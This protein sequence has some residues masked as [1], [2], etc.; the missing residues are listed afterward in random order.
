MEFGSPSLRTGRADLPHPALRSVVLPPRGVMNDPPIAAETTTGDRRRIRLGPR[1]ITMNTCP[2]QRARF[3]RRRTESPAGSARRHWAEVIGA[4]VH[5]RSSTFLRPL[6]PGPLQALRRF[7]GR[8]DSCSPSSSAFLR[9]ERRLYGEQVS[10]FYSHDLPAILSPTTCGCSVSP[11]HATC[12]WIEPSKLP[13]E[14]FPQRQLGASSLA[15]RLAT[16]RRP[17]RVSMRTDWPFTSCCSPPRVAT[18]Q[19]QADYEL[20]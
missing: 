8:S 20:R 2:D 9:H 12:R 7:Y 18:T 5:P 17:N 1:A 4:A 11:R 3:R 16:P 6:A 14:A 13:H 10:L 15:S 19:L